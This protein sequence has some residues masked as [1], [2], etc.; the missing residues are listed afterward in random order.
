VSIPLALQALA[1]NANI[2]SKIPVRY[3]FRIALLTSVNLGRVM[4]LSLLNV[5]AWVQND[6]R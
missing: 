6:P 5:D 2:A 3:D 4:K 1:V